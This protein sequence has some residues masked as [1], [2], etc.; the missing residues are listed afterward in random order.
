MKRDPTQRVP[1]PASLR[2]A[3]RCGG[4][5]DHRPFAAGPNAG[6]TAVA[7]ALAALKA[8]AM[9]IT[10]MGS[11]RRKPGRRVRPCGS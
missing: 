8:S 10:G 2:G 7:E 11:A 1:Q 6:C 5:A 9:G 4:P 3:R